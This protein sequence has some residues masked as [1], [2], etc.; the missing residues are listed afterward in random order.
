MMHCLALLVTQA[1]AVCSLA[2]SSVESAGTVIISSRVLADT[3]DAEATTIREFLSTLA[4]VAAAKRGGNVLFVGQRRGAEFAAVSEWAR[5]KGTSIV[6]G[7][8]FAPSDPDSDAVFLARL[9]AS[10]LVVFSSNA[11][12][13]YFENSAIWPN[14][15]REY[16]NGG[17]GV[18]AF[19][20]DGILLHKYLKDDSTSVD[21]ENIRKTWVERNPCFFG[22]GN[23]TALT[24]G[25]FQN[26][27]PMVP[28][29]SNGDTVITAICS[30][31]VP[32]KAQA[33]RVLVTHER[34]LNEEELATR[35]APVLLFSPNEPSFATSIP[36]PSPLSFDERWSSI[37]RSNNRVVYYQ[38]DGVTPLPSTSVFPNSAPVDSVPYRRPEDTRIDSTLFFSEKWG[39]F[40]NSIETKKIAWTHMLD[41]SSLRDIWLSY[42]FHYEL[43]TGFGGHPGDLESIQL[44]LQVDTAR[45]ACHR[46]INLIEVRGRCH[47]LSWYENRLMVER[48]TV[49]PIHV[50]VEEGKHASCPDRNADG[51]YT[52]GYDV[53]VRV[54]D[55]WGVRDVMA[56]NKLRRTYDASMFKPRGGGP[57]LRA[58]KDWHAGPGEYELIAIRWYLTNEL[59]QAQRRSMYENGVGRF[60]GH[61]GRLSKFAAT[62]WRILTRSQDYAF[63]ESVPISGRV[64]KE[65]WGW[66]V[67]ILP[68]VFEVPWI[69]GWLLPKANLMPDRSGLDVLYTPSTSRYLD[70]Y[71][72]SGIEDSPKRWA[73][74]AGLRVRFRVPRSSRLL[75]GARI[76]ARTGAVYRSDIGF[77][78]ELG[79]GA[80]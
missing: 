74:E 33:R 43:D 11:M 73:S 48:D 3:S 72:S 30:E 6:V 5:S 52:P 53:N 12:Q 68:L 64:Q 56:V 58:T 9:P 2:G 19:G 44:H 37:S 65:D 51:Y 34:Y 35:C 39:I 38:I 75:L 22:A 16:I 80:W 15:L 21:H 46:E 26:I 4:S 20:L 41:L 70:W 31:R 13:L 1:L 29:E 63:S 47:G 28:L 62:C 36:G 10:R 66:S 77:V 55:A 32:Y 57:T 60:V 79:F 7:D 24:W 25:W 71:I 17:G 67:V 23:D 59:T 78:G 54:N 27:E 40:R 45:G 42:Y 69:D 76:G 61:Q 14:A 49:L 18:I 50:F 8:W